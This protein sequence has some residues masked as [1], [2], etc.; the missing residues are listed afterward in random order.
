MRGTMTL[1]TRRGH[2][3]SG[4]YAAGAQRSVDRAIAGDDT[5]TGGAGASLERW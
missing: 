1:A 5:V 4:G 3:D 2:P